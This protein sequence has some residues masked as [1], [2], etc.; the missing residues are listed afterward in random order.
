MEGVTGGYSDARRGAVTNA[1]GTRL[2]MKVG[3][4]VR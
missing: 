1:D 4:S 3:M 2:F